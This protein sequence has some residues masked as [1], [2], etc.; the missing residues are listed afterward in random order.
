MIDYPYTY[1]IHAVYQDYQTMEVEYTTPDKPAILKGLAIPLASVNFDE[2]I[3]NNAPISE[4]NN[5]TAERHEPVVGHVGD[6][7]PTQENIEKIEQI[8]TEVL[9]SDI[10]KLIESF[11][12][13]DENTLLKFKSIVHDIVEEYLKK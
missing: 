11:E 9:S 4:W 7:T 2:Y 3:K 6:F 13:K 10:D 1:R 8:K 12:T 5:L